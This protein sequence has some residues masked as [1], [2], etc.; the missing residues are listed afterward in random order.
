M[1]PQCSSGHV[2]SPRDDLPYCSPRQLEQFDPG[3]TLGND[4]VVFTK[5]FPPG[6]C[7]PYM[8]SWQKILTDRPQ[9]DATQASPSH[10]VAFQTKAADIVAVRVR[11]SDQQ[12]MIPMDVPGA[13]KT[14]QRGNIIR[15]P[16]G[17]TEFMPYTFKLTPAQKGHQIEVTAILHFRHTEPYF[18]RALSDFYP[19]GITAQ[20]LLRNLT[21][22]DMKTATAKAKA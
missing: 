16:A 7:D 4:N 9:V 10:E 2:A 6:Q 18:I 8:A 19:P 15:F 13:R 11:I 1:Q 20:G 3:T 17:D 12:K 5:T 21:V 14:P 22:V